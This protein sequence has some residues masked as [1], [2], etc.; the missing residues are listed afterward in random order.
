M[1]TRQLR[2]NSEDQIKSRVH[3]FLGKEISL[4]LRDKTVLLGKVTKIESSF[5][6]MTNLRHKARSI[7]FTTISELYFD[8]KE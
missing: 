4:V 5:I 2:L 8:I 7:P 1:K 6:E 3:D